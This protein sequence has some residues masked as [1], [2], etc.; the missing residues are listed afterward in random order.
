MYL[1]IKNKKIKIFELNKFTER[2]KG[3]KF[4]LQTIDYGL[5][6]PNKRWISTNFLCQNIDIALTDKNDTIIFLL[7]NI[8]SEKKAN[9]AHYTVGKNIREVIEK[10]GGTLPEKLPTPEKSLK[11]IAKERKELEYE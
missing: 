7:E 6:F 10:N 9:Q 2:F 8:K 5:Y 4:T 1:Q 3:L 11:Q